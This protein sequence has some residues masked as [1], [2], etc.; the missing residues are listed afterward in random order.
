M[1]ATDTEHSFWLLDLVHGPFRGLGP[2]TTPVGSPLIKWTKLW[3]AFII[4]V[5]GFSFY[6]TLTIFF[7]FHA[8]N[9]MGSFN[10]VKESPYLKGTG[11]VAV[12]L[13]FCLRFGEN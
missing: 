9:I 11:G 13:F 3:S 8:T 4:R 7:L 10:L 1:H 5:M 12:L 2:C 6:L